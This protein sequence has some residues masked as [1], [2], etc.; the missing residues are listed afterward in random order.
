MNRT[1]LHKPQVHSY[2]YS[3][4][5]DSMSETRLSRKSVLFICAHNAARSQ[6]AEGYLKARYGDRF[7]VFS[8]GTRSSTINRHAIHIMNEIGID[9]SNQ[10][11]KSLKALEG[12]EMDIAVILCDENAG[13]CPVYPWA[14]E[15]VHVRF[16][17]PAEFTGN[18]EEVRARFRSLWDEI[19]HWIDAY[20]GNPG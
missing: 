10:F 3:K 18:E 13:I 5:L 20:F 17:D 1:F 2:L 12:R 9:I 4:F 6:M 11:S 8:A 19:T 16:T 7:D 14:K 15:V